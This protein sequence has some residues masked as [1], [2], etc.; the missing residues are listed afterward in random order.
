MSVIPAYTAAT[1]GQPG[2]AGAVNQLLGAHTSTILYAGV[3]TSAQ[4]TAGTGNA[5]S[6]A[7]WASQ[8]FVTGSSQTTLGYVLLQESTVGSTTTPMQVQLYA[9]NGTG[10]PAGAALA[11][12]TAAFEYVA[13]APHFVTF[14]LPAAV[15][16]S[17]TYHLV[18][19][20]V[21]T[22]SNYF[23]WGKSNQTSGAATS[24]DGVTW[25]AQSYG[26]LFEVFDQ[27]PAGLVTCTYDDG[28]SRWTWSQYNTTN[29]VSE[30][31][32]YTAGQTAGAYLQSNRT[33]SYSGGQ[34]TG[35]S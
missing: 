29:Q 22:S 20:M 2:N 31:C 34:L 4:T 9:D 7:A 8:T 14:P 18:V 11:S 5:P 25:T 19:P 23:G 28:G 32:E 26:L 35:V 3:Q 27:T 24:P 1:A 16:P 17:T 6:Y 13:F 30:Y 15:T 10:L 33:F 21:G 12:T